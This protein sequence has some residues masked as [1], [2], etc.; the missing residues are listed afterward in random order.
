MAFGFL[1]ESKEMQPF[2]D[3]LGGLNVIINKL[4][5]IAEQAAQADHTREPTALDTLAEVSGQH[6]D[7]ARQ[8]LQSDAGAQHD[9]TMGSQDADSWML[10]LH[11]QLAAAND[12]EDARA[13]RRAENNPLIETASAASRL[14]ASLEEQS[15]P[16]AR[17]R[18]GMLA[19]ARAQHVNL[20]PALQPRQSARFTQAVSQAP[21]PT[22]GFA[23][24]E[25]ASPR[26]KKG[27][28]KFANERRKQVG[29]IRKM[30]A[31]LRCRMLKKPCS[32]E[33]PCATCS[34]VGA[35]RIWRTACIRTKISDEFTL[36]NTSYFFAKAR[37]Q[38]IQMTGVGKLEASSKAVHVTLFED[39]DFTASSLIFQAGNVPGGDSPTNAGRPVLG[40]LA[41]QKDAVKAVETYL[42]IQCERFIEAES[43]N[44]LKVSLQT[45]ASLN[46]EEPDKLITRL[47]MLW[48]ATVILV[49]PESL[50][51]ALTLSSPTSGPETIDPS[52]PESAL[53]RAQTLDMVERYASQA[54]SQA[55]NDLARRLLARPTTSTFLATIVLLNCVERMAR[56]FRTF[57]P[58]SISS[59]LDADAIPPDWPLKLPPSHY[60]AQGPNFANL[61]GMV[62]RMRNLPPRTALDPDHQD[63]LLVLRPA[64]DMQIN[65]ESD[66]RVTAD[67]ESLVA[68]WL[69]QCDGS[70]AHL[71][72]QAG[73]SDDA[74]DGGSGA[75]DGRFSAPLVLGDALVFEDPALQDPFEGVDI[76]PA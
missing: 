1:Q 17:N 71:V 6:L 38:L 63:R 73:R 26:R 20:A 5:Q 50:S 41:E 23:N 40:L 15:L 68:I 56:L 45:L 36:Y 12:A 76:P 31:C 58:R 33:T 60:V 61:L 8:R 59:E 53:I 21:A 72:D 57:D 52:R 66:V 46:A 10:Q 44:F 65:P 14:N 4:D 2:V 18:S 35:P 37:D 9:N 67:R 7:L 70:V 43:N 51:W 39:E 28:R 19:T 69:A 13:Q 54:W 24:L 55:C 32:G 22:L 27:R 64:T 29:G 16:D 30:G 74:L 3:K 47:L 34:G 42:G 25:D 48:S 49:A 11:M 62:L 75:W